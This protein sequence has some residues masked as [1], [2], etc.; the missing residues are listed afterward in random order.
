MVLKQ[1]ASMLFLNTFH[2]L[3]LLSAQVFSSNAGI[4]VQSYNG[5][6]TCIT[7]AT[8]NSSGDEIANVNFLYGDIVHIAY[9]KI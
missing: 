7:I 6:E 1:P 5:T 4:Q 2:Y 3:L 8:R 9:F